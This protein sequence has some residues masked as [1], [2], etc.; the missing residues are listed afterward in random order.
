MTF[1]VPVDPETLGARL[2]AAGF[3]EGEV[4]EREGVFRFAGRCP[5]R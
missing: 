5:R 4:E 3:E 1:C 2:L